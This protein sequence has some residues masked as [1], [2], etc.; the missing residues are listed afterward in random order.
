LLS[1]LNGVRMTGCPGRAGVTIPLRADARLDD[2]ARRSATLRLQDALK[3]SNYRATRSLLIRL[4]GDPS[5][6]ALANLAAKDYCSEVTEPAYSEAG[7]YRDGRETRIVLAAP[8][9]PPPAEARAE[10]AERVLQLVN[11]ARS[12]PR[13]C[14][15]TLYPAAPPLRLHDTLSRV[16]LAHAT[17]MAQH[18]FFSHQG[19][20]GSYPT[21]RVTRGGYRWRSVGENISSGATTPEAV[22]SGW[23]NSPEH[24]AN[25]MAGAFSEM[26][27][28]Y[29]VN[30]QS[31]AGIYWVFV[32]T[33]R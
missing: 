1:A 14:G 18:S 23:M 33:R 21:D 8:F 32:A 4:G 27:I 26:G 2:A 9:A 30:P 3:A 25:L 31:A 11:Q 29:A 24:C 7:I 13:N 20:D 5:A 16:A 17:D 6:A 10:M 12:Q 22:V 28:A 15:A 19:R